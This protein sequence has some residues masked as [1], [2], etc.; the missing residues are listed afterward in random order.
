MLGVIFFFLLET[1][2]P[3][4]VSFPFLPKLY[5]L[6]LVCWFWFCLILVLFY[7][8]FC[9]LL[10]TFIGLQSN[11]KQYDLQSY[12]WA[13]KRKLAGVLDLSLGSAAVETRPETS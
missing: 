4:T 5:S 12:C 7:E 11:D 9:L 6:F 13:Q 3:V 10:Q 8:N 2:R 1:R